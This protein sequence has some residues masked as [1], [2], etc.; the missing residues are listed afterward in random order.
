MEGE[1]K[2]KTVLEQPQVGEGSEELSKMEMGSQLLKA[3]QKGDIIRTKELIEMG[4]DVNHSDKHGSTAVHLSAQG[5]HI[6]AIKLLNNKAKP[7]EPDAMGNTPVYIAANRGHGHI[8][9]FFMDAGVS[10]NTITQEHNRT[11]LHLAIINSH[12]AIIRRILT[13]MD[14]K[15]INQQDDCGDTALHY[16]AKDVGFR[17]TLFRPGFE[18]VSLEV[19]KLLLAVKGIEVNAVNKKGE[20]PLGTLKK[21]AFCRGGGH[22]SDEIA[23]L[24]RNYQKAAE[25]LE[26]GGGIYKKG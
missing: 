16:A 22:Y 5:G 18:T 13:T 14:I 12:E 26:R 15:I 11:I 3:A 20:T 4:V 25:L 21:Q 19:L 10:V 7:N 23:F 17:T 6:E 1:H 24:Q 2:K 9:Q 8:V